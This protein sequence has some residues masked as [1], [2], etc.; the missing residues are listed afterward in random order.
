MYCRLNLLGAKLALLCAL[1]GG[2]CPHVHAQTAAPV[3]VV[4]VAAETIHDSLSLS[5]T[6]TAERAAAL[7]MSTSG[8]VNKLYVDAGYRVAAGDVLLTLDH[9]LARYQWEAADA[10]RLQADH[11]LKDSRR[12]LLEAQKLA[13]QQS[14][15][16]T[17]VKNLASEVLEDQAALQEAAAQTGF[18]YGILQRHTLRAPY[19]GVISARRVEQGEWVTPGAPVLDLVAIDGLRID[20]QLSEDNL[21]NIEVLMPARFTLGAARETYYKAQVSVVVPVA[22]PTARTALVR[23]V[24]VDDIASMWPG[25][26]ARVELQLDTGRSGMVVPRDAVLRHA[27]GRVIVWVVTSSGDLTT[28]IERRV[29]SGR[30]FDGKVEIVSGLAMGDAVVVRG[31]ESLRS[32]QTVSVTRATDL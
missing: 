10:A 17:L 12:R 4:T 30:T 32:G 27:D 1:V 25:M 9:E 14:I 3:E 11:A 20:L 6:V 8:L 22:D 19:S 5:G 7:S 29:R 23:V 31:N 18:R 16:E 28:V 24:P 21:S 13:P 15:A 26:S 2:Y